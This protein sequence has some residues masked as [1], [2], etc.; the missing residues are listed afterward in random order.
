[1]RT[2]VD[3]PNEVES[4]KRLLVAAQ[5]EAEVAHLAHGGKLTS[6]PWLPATLGAARSSR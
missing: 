3:L 6:T 1:M 4:L 5:S 2:A